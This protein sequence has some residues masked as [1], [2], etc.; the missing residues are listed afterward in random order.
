MPDGASFWGSVEDNIQFVLSHPNGWEGAQQSQMRRAAI[1]AGL[2]SDS[3][4]DYGRIQ[5]VTEGEAS[6]HYC[7]NNGCNVSR[8]SLNSVFLFRTLSLQNGGIVIVD[9]GGG[10]VDLST[11]AK[12][13]TK[14]T[15]SFKE[16]SRPQCQW[17][18]ETHYF[19]RAN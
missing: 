9:A 6:L 7:L 5:F 14:I 17:D 15:T 12:T 10:T 11:Y 8:V 13:D 3:W 1:Q 16:I 4:E 2:I 18:F 19:F